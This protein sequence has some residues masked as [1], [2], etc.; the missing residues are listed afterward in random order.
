MYAHCEVYVIQ[1][2]LCDVGIGSPVINLRQ[3]PLENTHLVFLSPST[4]T[5]DTVYSN[6]TS[7][8]LKLQKG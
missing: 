5:T 4:N 2:N 7:G 1:S 8:N 3:T 6:V